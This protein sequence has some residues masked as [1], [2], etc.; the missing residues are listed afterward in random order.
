MKKFNKTVLMMISCIA[1]LQ[2]CKKDNSANKGGGDNN[3]TDTTVTIIPPTEPAIAN[4]QGFFLDNWQAK[5]WVAPS[6]T[7]SATKPASA[8]AV[9]V[10]V[11]LSKQITK[12]SNY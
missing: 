3:N 10:T 7:T 6:T 1:L 4:T 12:V 2:A 5:T 8:G 11:D 9:T